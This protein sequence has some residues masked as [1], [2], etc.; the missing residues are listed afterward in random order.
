MAKYEVL[1][2]RNDFRQTE[3]ELKSQFIRET[4][5]QMGVDLDEVWPEDTID[6]SIDQKIKLRNIL[7][8]LDLDIIDDRDGGVI[9]Y[10]E[11]QPI[12]EWKKCR[13]DLQTDL[14]ELDPARR[15]YIKIHVD[16]WSAFEI[17]EE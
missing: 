3:S 12:A 16:N 17:E 5:I 8:K 13:F 1:C 14:S 2:N 4:L 10:H 9:I 6:L 11:K 15:V 7:T